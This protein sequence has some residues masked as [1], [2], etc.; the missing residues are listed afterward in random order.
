[1]WVSKENLN[2]ALKSVD[3]S[4]SLCRESKKDV[5]KILRTLC[6]FKE[7]TY[8]LGDHFE[9]CVEGQFKDQF[10][11]KNVKDVKIV[12]VQTG[13]SSGNFVRAIRLDTH[14]VLDKSDNFTVDDVNN[15]T[16]EELS[17]ILRGRKFEAIERSTTISGAGDMG[18]GD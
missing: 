9:V 5:K 6:G 3:R 15:I 2:E 1:M 11:I 10:N 13:H 17:T 16:E 12:L 7:K 4:K 14:V 8:K 18:R